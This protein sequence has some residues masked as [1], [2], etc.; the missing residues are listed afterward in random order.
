MT[1]APIAPQEKQKAFALRLRYIER[2]PAAEKKKNDQGVARPG[3]LDHS[4]RL[5]TVLAVY[6]I[7]TSVIQ[8]NKSFL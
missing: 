1:L 6:N 3:L 2:M 8:I 7:R 4:G 5:V